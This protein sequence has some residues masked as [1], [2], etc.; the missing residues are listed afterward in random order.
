MPIS[1]PRRHVAQSTWK[2]CAF[3]GD[4]NSENELLIQ[5]QKKADEN[6]DCAMIIALASASH[7]VL[8]WTSDRLR[9]NY[10]LEL[11][12]IVA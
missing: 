10:P 8:D 9:S 7:R 4:G 12:M 11:E 2:L 5:F 1:H 3:N 6:C